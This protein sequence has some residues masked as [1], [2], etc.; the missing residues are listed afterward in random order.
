[1]FASFLSVQKAIVSQSRVARLALVLAAL[2]STAA[3]VQ[4]AAAADMQRCQELYGAWQRYKGASTN[5]SGRDIASQT[6]LQECRSG[7]VD[8]GVAELEMLLKADRIPLPATSAAA[9]R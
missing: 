5:S 4:P 1:M 7:H 2:G 9:A 3:L 6:A 8:A